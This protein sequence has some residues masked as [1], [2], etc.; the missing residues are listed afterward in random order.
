MR[1]TFP[2]VWTGLVPREVADAVQL[3]VVFPLEPLVADG[4]RVRPLRVRRLAQ[5][6]VRNLVEH[7]D[8]SLSWDC[9]IRMRG[10]NWCRWLRLALG[11]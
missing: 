2:A 4:A 9:K 11:R 5:G 1:L 10:G 7:Y 3:E 8:S 6:R